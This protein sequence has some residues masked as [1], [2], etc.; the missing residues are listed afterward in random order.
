M[1]SHRHFLSASILAVGLVVAVGCDSN[2]PPK[3]SASS[4]SAPADALTGTAWTLLTYQDASRQAAPAA[5][6]PPATLT[7]ARGGNLNGSTGCNQ[8]S[9]TYS[10]TGAKLTLTLGPMTQIACADPGLQAQETAIVQG[11]PKV[12]GFEITGSDLALSDANDL[13]L[14]SY[15]ANSTALQGTAWKVTGLNT[16]K[17]VEST[18]A[19]QTLTANFTIGGLFTGFGGCNNLSATYAT[20]GAVGVSISQLTSTSLPCPKDAAPLEARYRSALARVA[21]YEINGDQ[22]TLRATDGT[23]QVT[24]T[25]SS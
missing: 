22:L 11:I 3:G 14:F 24:A 13:L 21:T 7:F 23:T 12:T 9:G 5:A 17:A 2:G 25:R 16:G 6:I 18:A 8:F 19:I 1:W 10:L 15:S 20:S 4:S